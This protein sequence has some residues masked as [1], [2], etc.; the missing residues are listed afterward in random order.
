M[1]VVSG[2]KPNL[3]AIHVKGKTRQPVIVIQI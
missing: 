1:Y 3:N 2:G